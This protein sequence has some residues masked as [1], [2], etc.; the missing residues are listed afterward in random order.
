MRR[1]IPFFALL[2]ATTACGSADRGGGSGSGPSNQ[3]AEAAADAGVEG[4]AG[5]EEGPDIGTTAAP[6][7]AF[8]YRYGFRLAPERI[9]EVQDQHQQICERLT[10]A[11]CRITGMSY[12]AVN[13]EDVEAMLSFAVD[14]TLARQFGREAVQRV[15]AADGAVTESEIEG[16]DVGTSLR[17][18][19]RTRA[20]LEAELA[21]IETR[22]RGIDP[23]SAAKTD[24]EQQAGRLREQIRS[25]R[26]T[27]E[28][29]QQSLATT[30][31]LLRYGSGRFAPGPAPEPTLGQTARETGEDALD[32]LVMMLRILIVL[33]PWLA[34]GLI[35]WWG[36]ARLRRRFG[37]APVDAA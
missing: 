18:V 26:E 23:V 15:T 2:L 29:Q 33:S 21:R 35:G 8:N 25:L 3:I 12:R 28:A 10:L 32:M 7:V 9:A 4:T 31:I 37:A 20:D 24:L 13:D 6:D 30:P 22:L 17:A 11:R 14:P 5:R 34:A 1:A 16:T 36:V 19:G 27:S